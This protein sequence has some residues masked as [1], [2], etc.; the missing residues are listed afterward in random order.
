MLC[1]RIFRFPIS[2]KRFGITRRGLL[3]GAR[4][5]SFT[6]KRIFQALD[7]LQDPN[8]QRFEVSS[9]WWAIVMVGRLFKKSGGPAEDLS[10]KPMAMYVCMDGW[11][12]VCMYVC[13]YACMYVMYGCMHACMLCMYVCMDVCMYACMYVMY[14]WMYVCMDVCMHALMY[15]CMYV[16]VYECRHV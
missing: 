16:C 9:H 1:G 3:Q 8:L 4:A 6:L 5:D 14:A 12:D 7:A 2:C 11:M 15:V 13:M 10:K